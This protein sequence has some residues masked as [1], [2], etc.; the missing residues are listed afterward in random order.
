MEITI[1]ITANK[2]G[3]RF[4]TSLR[5]SDGFRA[6]GSGHT[7]ES[8]CTWSAAMVQAFTEKARGVPDDGASGE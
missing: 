6:K 5:T 3:D 8:V 1:K 2:K 7:A 4:K